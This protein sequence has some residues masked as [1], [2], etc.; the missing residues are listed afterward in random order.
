MEEV[1]SQ[2]A[3]EKDRHSRLAMEAAA[4]SKTRDAAALQEKTQELSK[5]KHQLD[6]SVNCKLVSLCIMRVCAPAQG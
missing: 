2:L 1:S 5:L 4:N 3:A 6:R